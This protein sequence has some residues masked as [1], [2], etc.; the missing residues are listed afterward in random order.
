MATEK[1]ELHSARYSIF[2]VCLSCLFIVYSLSVFSVS[3]SQPAE[4]SVPSGFVTSFR[5]SLIPHRL[6]S[7][8]G[9]TT[10]LCFSGVRQRVCER[11]GSCQETT[12]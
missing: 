1:V 3:D 10:L 7:R 9:Y 2:L 6:H 11:V 12:I 5:L 4:E 8:S